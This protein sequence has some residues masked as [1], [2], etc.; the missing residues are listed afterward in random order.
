MKREINGRIYDTGRGEVIASHGSG[1]PPLPGISTLY[2]SGEGLYFIVEEQEAHGVDGWES[3]D[4]E[5][6]RSFA[7]QSHRRGLGPRSIQRRLSAVRS[8]CR[9]LIREGELARDPAAGVR[10]PK[11]A[12]RLPSALDTDTMA[13]LLAFRGDLV[14]SAEAASYFG[15][16]ELAA[17]LRVAIASIG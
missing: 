10:A 6:V 15:P 12:K 5:H 14:L 11:A 16:E 1:S 9:F 8:L 17:A 4:S 2:R 7:A 3:L 13:R